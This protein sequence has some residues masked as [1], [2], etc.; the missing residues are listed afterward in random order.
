[1]KTV[2]AAL[3]ALIVLLTT[4]PT[5]AG[6]A[7]LPKVKEGP[8]PG[9]A[10]LYAPPATSPALTNGDGWHARPIMVSGAAAYRSGEFVYQ[11]YLY[12]DY[13]A[14]TTDL[15]FQPPEPR[16][17]STEVIF[18]SQTGDV[19][20]PT[21]EDRYG[22]NAADLVELR[23][24]LRRNTVAYRLTLNTALDG[25][26]TAIAIGIDTDGGDEVSDWGHGLG[27]LGPLDLEH[28][29]YTDGTSADLD[30]VPVEV[31]AD[32]DT[33]QIDVRAPRSLLEPGSATWR[34]YA[35]TGIADG[36][37]G[38]A[39]L[40]DNP[41][42]GSPGGRHGTAAP[43]V[44]NVAFRLEVQGDE[45]MGSLA[46]AV[47][48]GLGSRGGFGFGNRRDHGQALAL[49]SR[50]ISDFAADIDFGKLAA[51]TADESLV[52]QTGYMNRIYVSSLDLGEG[53]AAERPW[54]LGDL[55]PYS[56][57]V[58]T[59]YDSEQP[60][61]FTLVLHSLSA[62]YNQFQ[63]FS[64]NTYRDLGEDRGSIVL[65]VEGRGPDGWYLHEAE[66]D[67]FEAWADVARRYALDPER[68]AIN[69][70]SM[71]GY[72]T[73]RL[74]TRYPDLFGKAFPVVGPPGEGI[75]PGAGPVLGESEPGTNTH[76]LLDNLR[77][78][79]L[80][81]W[82]GAADELVPLPGPTVQ[83]QRLDD[84]GY[85]YIYD[86]F[87]TDHFGLATIDEWD[88]GKAFLGD[89]FV[90]RDPPH[91]TYRI[92][93]AGDDGS[94]GLVS[95]HAYWL[96]DVE[97]RDASAATATGLVDARSL[98][99]GVG[100]PASAPGAGAGTEPLPYVERS[101]SWGDA[102]VEDVLNALEITLTN[103]SAVTV[104][105]RRA[106]L[107][108]RRDIDLDVSSDGDATL[109]LQGD[110]DPGVSVVDAVT[111]DP[112]P[113]TLAGDLLSISIGAGDRMIHVTA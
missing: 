98:G 21:D 1:M 22:Y 80:L 15:P 14:N 85:R 31:S 68:I 87:T 9:P 92:L 34:H 97:I 72:G 58:P 2:R 74:A 37:G 4:L 103:V 90:D 8:P 19:V 13:G 75:W 46:P 60:A 59:T 33:N 7:S 107:R 83:V 89:A 43:P 40:G 41:T 65:T 84:L 29:L 23:V 79:P 111:G 66:L 42:A 54:L 73:Y 35:V 91:V 112:V 78:I 16:P 102:P 39:P 53:V 71:G 36:A 51:G 93:P 48:I 30:G 3:A 5:G 100:D 67:V 25:G 17:P 62:S 56:L 99:F 52:P 61:P 47:E 50:D 32:L 64:P 28:V 57:Y 101:R 11:D 63:V 95:D 76:A 94:L 55:Q 88:R 12:D 109:S 110:F 10:A 113:F 24:D 38:F 82:D 86:V 69:G 20:Y 6:G 49:A 106:R 18:G 45:P 70:Y 108:T 96:W 105:A 26:A 77:N 104:G 44:L 27:A 81:I